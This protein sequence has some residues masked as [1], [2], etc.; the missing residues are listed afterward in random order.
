MRF[1]NAPPIIKEIDVKKRGF[2]AII[3]R[4]ITNIKAITVRMV[5]IIAPPIFNPKTEFGFLM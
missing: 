1:P 2:F 4:Y 3:N 5:D